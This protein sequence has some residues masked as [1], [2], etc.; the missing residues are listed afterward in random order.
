MKSLKLLGVTFVVICVSAAS[1][2]A[3]EFYCEVLAVEGTA[4]M[5]RPSEAAKALTEGDLL[6]VDDAIEV[7]ADSYVDISYDKDWSNV[8]R[9]E[10]N[11]KMAIKSINPTTLDLAEGG[12]YAK[13]KALMTSLMFIKWVHATCIITSF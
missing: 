1:A 9:I 6:Q 13:L 10:E 5:T 8:T 7:G 3:E 2:W 11:S 12:V 4:T